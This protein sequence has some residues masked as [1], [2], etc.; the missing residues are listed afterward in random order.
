[1]FCSRCGSELITDPSH[2]MNSESEKDKNED[3]DFFFGGGG[4]VGG[5]K[6]PKKEK[7]EKVNEVTI[8]IG[9]IRLKDGELKVVR[10]STLPLKVTGQSVSK[11]A[12]YMY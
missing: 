12:K 5:G 8:Q 7:S 1:M 3:Q 10:E 6:K 9:L 2:L 4:G 11:H